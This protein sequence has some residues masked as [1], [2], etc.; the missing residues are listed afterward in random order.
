MIP[1]PEPGT[2]GPAATAFSR[3]RVLTG[4]V[5]LF[6]V[7]LAGAAFAQHP[8]V[9]AIAGGARPTYL[10]ERDSRDALA[11]SIAE[12]LFWNEQMKEHATFFVMLM[13]G[14]AL[15]KP[16][17]EAQ[18]FE[19]AF[20]K[21]Q[22]E[23]A[24]LDAAGMAA[25]NRAVSDEVRRY[26]DWEYRMRDAQ[27]AGKLGS[28]VW[29]TF[30]HHTAREGEYF[31]ARLG[32]LSSG[33]TSVD[34]Q[35]AAE[36]WTLVMGEHAGFIAHLLDPEEQKLVE[37]AMKTHA[38]FDELHDKDPI[39]RNKAIKAVED[40]LDFKVAAAKGIETGEIRSIIDPALADHVRREAI[41]AAD[42]L[43]R[44]A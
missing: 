38:A 37:K 25:F 39:P 26:A 19:Q 11:H 36:F 43:R 28:L 12:H 9:A 10:P 14:E 6:G 32:R 3:R 34:P 8:G 22:S 21:R 4:A 44:A 29:P 18:A 27:A 20:A 30:F 42:E 41:K 31:V 15:A 35:A 1:I 16:R 23:A 33:D 2:A 17:A 5:T 24:R 13:P 40:I 7:G